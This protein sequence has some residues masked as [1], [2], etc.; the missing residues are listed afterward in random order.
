MTLL[1]AAIAVFVSSSSSGLS[2]Q[3]KSTCESILHIYLRP[4]LIVQ[5]AEASNLDGDY[6]VRGNCF[7]TH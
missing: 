2:C 6:P 7:A 1:N 5:V 3:E 4:E